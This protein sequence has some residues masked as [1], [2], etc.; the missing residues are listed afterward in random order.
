MTEK[1]IDEVLLD[2]QNELKAPKNQ[3]NSFGKYK[4][5]STEDVLEA[6]KPILKSKGLSLVLSDSI[7]QVSDRVY[8]KSTARLMYK[9]TSIEVSAFARESITKKGMDDSQITGTASSYARKYA[10]NGMFLIDDSKD[11]DSDEFKN[12]TNSQNNQQKQNQEQEP[13]KLTI[14]QKF[15]KN[16]EWVNKN[17][18][19]E[20]GLI[21]SW[22]EMTPDKAL[23]A[24]SEYVK[25]MKEQQKEE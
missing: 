22:K 9:K 5:R 4:Y 17:F 20:L 6:L 21:N 23:K 2:V 10:L 16:L 15:E 14:K 19:P 13:P 3:Y 12:Q 11:A 8:V 18:H 24:I 1:T 7:E 25:A